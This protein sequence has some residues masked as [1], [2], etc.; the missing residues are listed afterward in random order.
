[1]K[2]VDQWSGLVLLIISALIF[3]GSIGLPYGSVR[4]PGPGFLPL[5]LG[6]V[7]GAMSIGLIV[8]TSMQKEGAKSIREILTEKIRWGKV[9]SVLIALFL[10]GFLMGYIGFLTVTFL[11]MV[12]LLWFVDPQPWKSVIGWALVGS[13]GSYLV[14]EVWMKLRLPKGFFG[15]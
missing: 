14:F 15:I 2:K 1:M 4:E 6:I 12:F 13:V 8:K 5:W 3:W 11:F 9:L 10:Y 7:L